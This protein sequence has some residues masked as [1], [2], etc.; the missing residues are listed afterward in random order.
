MSRKIPGSAIVPG[1]I[2]V[3]QITGG[4]ND[5]TNASYAQA[6]TARTTANDA[7][8]QANTAYGQA[9]N[10]YSSANLSY[11]Q[12]NASYNVANTKLASVGGTLSGDLIITGNLTVSGNSTTLNTEVLTV[13]DAEVVLLSNVA[14]TPALN[15][16]II[17]NRGTSTN[18]FLRWDEA[19]DEWGWSDSGT[20][21]YYFEDLRAGL[22]TTNTTFGTVNTSLG[23]INTSYQAAYAQANTAHGTANDAYGQANTAY[24]QANSAYG[25]ANNRVLKAGDTMTGQLNISSGGLLVT[26]NVGF[27]TASPASKLTV[28]GDVQILS[29]NYLNF[30]NTAQQTYIR[31]PASNTIAF[32]T[33]STEQMRLDSSGNVGIGSAA[34]TSQRLYVSVS[35]T[36]SANGAAIDANSYPVS[37]FMAHSSG[38]GIRGLEIGAPTGGVASPVY[39]KVAET[40]ARFA[41]L[42]N[43]GTEQFTILNDGNVGIGTASPAAKFQVSDSSTPH[44]RSHFSGAAAAGNKGALIFSHNRNSDGTQETLGYIQ[45]VAED[46]QSAG[47]IRFVARNNTDVET[48]RITSGGKIGIGTTSTDYAKVH[49]REGG[50]TAA[51]I[52]TG[53][54]HYNADSATQ[55]KY[56]LHLDAGGNGSVVSQGQGPSATLLIGNYYDSRGI[57]TML[58][59]GGG[60]P[61]DGGNGYGK[62][63]MVKGGNSDN[64][65]GYIGGRL[66]LAGGSGYSG[67]AY[68]ANYGPVVL[69]PQ[70]GNVGIGNSGPGF[71]FDLSDA[72]AVISGTATTGSN[73]KGIR[74]YNT[75]T[76]TTNNAIGLW[77]AT[78]P[79][80]AGI[81]SFRASA[82]TGWDTCLAFYTH[83]NAVSNLNDATEKMRIHGEGYVTMPL[84][85]RFYA[86]G[87]VGGTHASGSFVRYGYTYVNVG[88]HYSSTNGRFTAPVTGDY[89]LFWGSIAATANDVYR[90]SLY[91]NGVDT[92]VQ[93]RVDTTSTGSEYGTN[94][95]RAIILSLAQNDYV[96][97]YYA[98]DAGTSFYPGANESSP[99]FT[100]FGGYLLG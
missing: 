31:A 36:D 25:A 92:S 29:T 12:A 86:Y 10:A 67:G 33:S 57:I 80:Q 28:S 51:A 78:G 19:L 100:H 84:Q 60:S 30:T 46:N 91:K 99:A 72:G 44:I 39:I 83:V 52:S 55:S 23:T 15:A 5:T 24:G 2:T 61:S 66:F 16:G 71:K 85:P 34:N 26:G 88:S 93:L 47:G 21:T 76:A 41:I 81:A 62:D 77:M 54:P 50:I 11:E 45:G 98:A 65:N 8:G 35:T 3:T 56:V 42:N 75:T 82:D 4:L 7:Y 14:G 74:I 96:Q 6:N 59:A 89:Y 48:F 38:G 1:T 97:I 70:G 94:G 73:M 68:N 90:F 20:T 49:I 32:G 9:N 87:N 13:E 37:R 63:L 17:V 95:S 27:G 79:H 53:W 69:Q 43:S 22:A 58:G 18:T 40:S 64:G